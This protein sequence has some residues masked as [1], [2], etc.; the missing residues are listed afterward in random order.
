MYIFV[1]VNRTILCTFA[2]SLNIRKCA[3]NYAFNT[4]S[5]TLG[6]RHLLTQGLTTVW[7]RAALNVRKGVGLTF[8]ESAH[9]IVQVHLV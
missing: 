1:H 4:L 8:D 9:K 6:I 7:S 2:Q 3:Q 5:A